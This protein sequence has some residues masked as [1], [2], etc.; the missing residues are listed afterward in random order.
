MA[1]RALIIGGSGQIGQAVARAL[2]AAGWAVTAA[3][4]RPDRF[5]SDIDARAIALDREEPGAL[6]RAA[7]AGFDA[8]VDTVAYDDGHAR[9]LLEVA[10]GIG[11][12]VVISSGSVYRDGAGRTLDEAASS[13]F[14]R[15]PVPI[16]EDQPTVAPGPATYSTR[17][18]AL[19]QA[20]L[21]SAGPPVTILRPFALHG[22]GSTHPREWWFAKRILDG[23]P[24]IRL[25]F[26]GQG[27]FPR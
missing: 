14:P 20:L 25:A 12:F 16:G 5:P 6:A 2:S 17:K 23:R 1:R 10:G 15:F 22:P 18:A 26:G 4:K 7:H 27:R 24:R 21:Q 11:T 8:V 19:E 9:Q 3:Q 13:G